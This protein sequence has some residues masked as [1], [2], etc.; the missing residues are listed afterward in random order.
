MILHQ[1]IAYRQVTLPLGFVFQTNVAGKIRGSFGFSCKSQSTN[2][3]GP[4]DHPSGPNI[5]P[6][7]PGKNAATPI[8]R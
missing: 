4:L 1:N 3:A 2:F 6:F 8:S 5:H 7:R